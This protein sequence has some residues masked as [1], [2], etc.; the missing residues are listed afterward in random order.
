MNMQDVLKQYEI[1]LTRYFEQIALTLEQAG[2]GDEITTLKLE[3][4]PGLSVI[5]RKN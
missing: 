4:A 5:W 2:A 1:P 3:Y